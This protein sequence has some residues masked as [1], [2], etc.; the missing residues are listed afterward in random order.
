MSS[1]ARARGACGGACG[2]HDGA[3][4]IGGEGHLRDIGGVN[5][6]LSSNY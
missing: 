1:D 3:L 4:G 2:G 5:E 6:S